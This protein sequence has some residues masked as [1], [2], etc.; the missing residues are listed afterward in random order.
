MRQCTCHPR[1]SGDRVPLLPGIINALVIPAKAGTV[2]IT[3]KLTIMQQDPV[4]EIYSGTPWEAN[5]LQSLL[6]DAGIESFT[7]NDV[8]G[9]FLYHPINAD[10]VKLMILESDLA[11]AMAI[12]R[13]FSRP[14]TSE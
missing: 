3:S 7:K 13:D 6:K 12:V 14:A 5:L 4:I 8:H 9:T 2:S 10:N 11:D 1:G